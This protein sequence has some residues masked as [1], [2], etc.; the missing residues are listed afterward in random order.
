MLNLFLLPLDFDIAEIKL[1]IYP[2]VLQDD[3]EVV[4]IDCG[5]PHF[6]EKIEEELVKVGL[7]L[8]RVTKLIMTHHDHDHMGSLKEIKEKYPSIEVLCSKEQKPFITGKSKSL[9]L[10]QAELLQDTLPENQKEAGLAFISFISAVEPVK[11]VETVNPGDLIRC[12]GD[13][14]IIDTKGHMPGHISLYVRQEKTLIAGDALVIEN[15]K[16]C[17]AMPQFALNMKDAQDSVKA[18]L[19]YDIEKVIC[20][21]GGV[22]DKD[23][24]DSLLEIVSQFSL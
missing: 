12:C 23:V 8:S 18:L 14:E 17:I 1:T 3:K 4:L 6:M 21:H 11:D 22:C 16:L 15:G 7:S 9:R 13:V 24:R 10:I 5:Y 20:Y 2:V 19:D